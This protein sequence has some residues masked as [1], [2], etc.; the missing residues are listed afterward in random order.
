MN[1]IHAH[2]S[3]MQWESAWDMY[4]I[5]SNYSTARPN[6]LRSNIYSIL[7]IT[8]CTTENKH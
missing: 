3:E 1:N 6:K 7:K 8:T 5:L 4:R 2:A